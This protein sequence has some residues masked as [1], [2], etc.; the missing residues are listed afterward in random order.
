MFLANN[1]HKFYFKQKGDVTGQ[2]FEG[3][4]VCKCVLSNVE[5]I[6]VGLRVDRY[7][8]GSKTLN[9]ALALMNRTIA[10]CE[11]RIIKAPTWW[12]ESDS[13]RSLYDSNILYSVFTEVMKGEKEWA[14]RLKKEADEAEAAAEKSQKAKEAKKKD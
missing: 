6:E 8:G 7:N 13:G 12:Q 5:M 2:S 9:P 4:F 3:D 14:D 10:E 1:E 11:V